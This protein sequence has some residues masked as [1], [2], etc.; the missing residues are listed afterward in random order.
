MDLFSGTELAFGDSY[1]IPRNPNTFQSKQLLV[2]SD[3]ANNLY[4]NEYSIDKDLIESS[5]CINFSASLIIPGTR[6][7]IVRHKI[8]LIV[9]PTQSGIHRF[10]VHLDKN[11]DDSLGN[12]SLLSLLH[13]SGELFATHDFN[14][15]KSSGIAIN[16]SVGTDQ[17]GSTKAVIRMLD[18]P[19]LRI[20]YPSLSPMETSIPE[21]YPLQDVGMFASLFKKQSIGIFDAI[22]VTADFGELRIFSASHDGK[23]RV[24]DVSSGNVLTCFDLIAKMSVLSCQQIED[25]SLRIVQ[26]RRID[27]SDYFEIYTFTLLKQIGKDIT[28]CFSTSINYVYIKDFTAR[29]IPQNNINNEKE[30]FCLWVIVNESPEIWDSDEELQPY[31]LMKCEFIFSFS[32]IEN[33][34]IFSYEWESVRP[35]CSSCL[36]DN[37][38]F[39]YPNSE[40]IRNRIFDGNNYSFDVVNRAVQVVCKQQQVIQYGNW[41]ALSRFLDEFLSSGQLKH[42]YFINAGDHVDDDTE[43]LPDETKLKQSYEK[44]WMDF[45]KTCDQLQEESLE[46]IAIWQSEPIG[47]I[48]VVQKCRFTIYLPPDDQMR[49]ICTPQNKIAKLLFDLVKQNQL[50]DLSNPDKIS[51]LVNNNTDELC[52][53]I[54]IIKFRSHYLQSNFTVSLIA[55]AIRSIVLTRLKISCIINNLVDVIPQILAISSEDRI[56]PKIAMVI[57]TY[58]SRIAQSINYYTTLWIALSVRLVSHDPIPKQINV[59][60][61]FLKYGTN[62]KFIMAQRPICKEKYGE[63]DDDEIIPNKIIE[64]DFEEEED[65]DNDDYFNNNSEL[66]RQNNEILINEDEQFEDGEYIINDDIS[67][68]SNIKLLPPPSR[69]DDTI[70]NKTRN[71][72]KKLQQNNQKSSFSRFFADLIEGILIVLWPESKTLT[73]PCFLAESNFFDALKNYCSLNEP[74]SPELA[75][76]FEF[77]QAIACSGQ[78]KPETAWTMFQEISKGVENGDLIFNELLCK[79]YPSPSVNLKLNNNHDFDDNSYSI[80]NLKKKKHSLIEYY[81]KVMFIF[82]EH[83]HSEYVILAGKLAIKYSKIDKDE[84][85]LSEIYTTLFTQHLIN[86]NYWEAVRSVLHNPNNK[87]QSVCLCQLITHLLDTRQTKIL[88]AL[89]YGNLANI[90]IEIIEARCK[91]EMVGSGTGNFSMYNIAYAFYISRCEYIKAAKLMYELSIRLRHEIQDRALLQR[92]CN[93]LATIFQ[94]MQIV[95]DEGNASLLLDDIDNNN[96]NNGNIEIRR[97]E[98]STEEIDGDFEFVDVS[99]NINNDSNLIQNI[100]KIQI[101][102]SDISRELLKLEARLSLMDADPSIV[103]PLDESGILYESLRY[104]R[105]DMA[106]LLIKEFNLKPND[107]LTQ[108]TEEAIRIDNEGDI[109][110]KEINANIQQNEEKL[111]EWV[112]CNRSFIRDLNIGE[113][114][115]QPHWRIVISYLDLSLKIF[116][117]D[118]SILRTIANTFLKFSIKLP[119]WLVQRYSEI[120]FGDLL[121]LLIDFGDF[122]DAF[123]ILLDQIETLKKHLKERTT[124]QIINNPLAKNNNEGPFEILPLPH[125]ELLLQLAEKD[126]KR[127]NLPIAETKTKLKEFYD[128][129]RVISRNPVKNT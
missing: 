9:V 33:Q 61:A 113:S 114:N 25:I 11:Q 2:R 49:G 51:E 128:Y 77:F 68:N 34:E 127:I 62:D 46:P 87:R 57:S 53:L 109:N 22:I 10:Y 64:N 103:P 54:S 111:P 6:L 4:L 96:N 123:S 71:K 74:F 85:L 17:N 125:I 30:K 81:N 124:K 59:A 95:E 44:F 69:W 76:S 72:T 97:E 67:Y 27:E 39:K 121:R 63:D 104:K 86:K 55:M 90:V 126:K 52:R 70:I 94:T 84:L 19:V 50:S 83:K 7:F 38:L 117:H 29:I 78:N 31:T 32:N 13:Q 100:N 79:L 91:A 48:G 112:F 14:A 129:H 122:S 110:N 98:G 89:P 18:G 92:R 102:K 1:F 5:L 16:V 23:L 80:N 73:L 40:G 116:P 28:I 15:W 99:G 105:Y 93:T 8:F 42:L 24:L 115:Q 20:I 36:S 56:D 108:I 58:N 21:E 101:T 3:G 45:L 119:V 65:E 37:R 82:K 88:V 26:P 41:I 107:L 75:Y 118:T 60:Q 35:A 12:V 47:L 43:L 120:N 66:I 106:W